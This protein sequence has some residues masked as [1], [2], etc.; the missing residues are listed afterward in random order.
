MFSPPHTNLFSLEPSPVCE[1]WHTAR[2]NR[3]RKAPASRCVATSN[4]HQPGVHRHRPI[5]T[6]TRRTRATLLALVVED[7]LDLL[8]GR[9]SILLE[10][11]TFAGWVSP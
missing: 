5:R 2:R 6:N 7:L 8:V 9:A 4:Q 3:V 10:R 11:T 1:H